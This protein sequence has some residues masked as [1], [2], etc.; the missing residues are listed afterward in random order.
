VQIQPAPIQALPE[1][2]LNEAERAKPYS[3]MAARVWGWA[4]EWL[5][6][7]LEAR[8]DDVLSIRAA[9]A[10]SGWSYEALRRRVSADPGLNAGTPGA[11]AIR[12]RDLQRLGPPR[13]RR[14]LASALAGARAVPQLVVSGAAPASTPFER[15]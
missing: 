14:K 12:R 13:G 4:A 1:L 3:P 2:F 5:R 6:V 15:C 8:L 7:A 10:E 9:A 11:P